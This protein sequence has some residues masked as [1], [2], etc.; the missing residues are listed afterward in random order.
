M[1]G[2]Q[3][4]SEVKWHCILSTRSRFP[5]VFQLVARI[6][7]DLSNIMEQ[8][9]MQD[10]SNIREQATMQDLSHHSGASYHAGLEQY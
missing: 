2:L 3:S 1:F 10:L 6:M 5:I 9:T 4:S 8:A 7:C